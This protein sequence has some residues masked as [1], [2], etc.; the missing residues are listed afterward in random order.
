MLAP[1]LESEKR[2]P[3]FSDSKSRI[4]SVE[5]FLFPSMLIDRILGSLW[6]KDETGLP[7]KAKIVKKQ[8]EGAMHLFWRLWK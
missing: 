8:S 2:S 5:R 3:R 1:W 4:S 6:P 7:S